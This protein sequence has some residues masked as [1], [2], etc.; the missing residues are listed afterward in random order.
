MLPRKPASSSTNKTTPLRTL[1]MPRL[2]SPALQSS[3]PPAP[4]IYNPHVRL[5]CTPA[6]AL[7][8]IAPTRPDFPQTSSTP[9]VSR[10]PRTNSSSPHL[11]SQKF[12]VAAQTPPPSVPPK[13]KPSP[14]SARLHKHPA[15]RFE[16]ERSPP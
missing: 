8:S 10:I 4:P 6:A 15:S 1:A 13:T 2:P 3:P 11:P 5:S 9:Q 7:R 12:A 14:E 16:R